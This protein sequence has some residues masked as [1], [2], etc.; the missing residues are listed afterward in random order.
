MKGHAP[1][2]L[3]RIEEQGLNVTQTG[4]QLFYDGWLLRLLPGKV[5][6]ARSV[7]AFYP[8]SLDL[9]L[10]IR[11]CEGVYADAGLPAIWRITPFDQPPQLD[12][13]LAQRGYAQYEQT[14]VMLA[15]L[16]VPPD[17]AHRDDVEI[18]APPAADYC[19]AVAAIRGSTDEQRAA[20]EARLAQS[21]TG[22][23]CVVARC[24]G[25]YVASAQLAFEGDVAG[26]FDIVTAAD[27]R[28]RGHATALC[29][30]M[31]NWGWSHGMRAAYLQ[32][33]AD[34]AAAL[35]VYRKF[36]FETR[37]TYHYRGRPEEFA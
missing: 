21:A 19:A 27:A 28:G 25:R 15:P 8:S 18:S 14:Q 23:Y 37:Y 16:A 12:A 9:A 4:R 29:A 6:R 30:H 13:A 31:L 22:R 1:V 36:G 10:K 20:H 33:T 24:D 34:N 3:R 17:V 2:D 5:K 7:N 26:L 32:V 11:H 35:A